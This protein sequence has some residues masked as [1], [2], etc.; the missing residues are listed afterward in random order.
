M[1]KI[2]YI[3]ILSVLFVGF[4]TYS[5]QA[6]LNSVT[7]NQS[8][9]KTT[10]EQDIREIAYNQL[11][12][13]DKE[14]T[15][16]TWQNSKFSKISLREGMG[17]INDKSYVGQEVYLIDFPTK[18]KSLPNNMIV[19]IEMHKYKLIGYGYAD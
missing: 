7:K 5:S 8:A 2:I 6:K 18:S 10:K 15:A 14:R 16:G 12:A 4:S 19:Y 3:V 13:E 11:T 1:K 17:N 9:G